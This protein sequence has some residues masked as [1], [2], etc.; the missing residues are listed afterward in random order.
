MMLKLCMLIFVCSL[1]VASFTVYLD[2]LTELTSWF[3]TLYHTNYAGWIPVHLKD[4]AELSNSHPE[5]A[6]KFNNDKFVVH[7]TR[8]VFSGIPIDQ[9]DEQNNA[10]IKGDGGV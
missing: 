3:F 4:V 10:S 2:A 5:G 9:A 8:W 1:Q 6:K 7:K